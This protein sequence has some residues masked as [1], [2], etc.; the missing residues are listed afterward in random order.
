ML[1]HRRLLWFDKSLP[2]SAP[3]TLDASVRSLGYSVL[4][5]AARESAKLPVLGVTMKKRNGMKHEAYDSS[6]G[7]LRGSV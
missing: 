4:C 7:F 3:T 2:G 6:L 5:G 1:F